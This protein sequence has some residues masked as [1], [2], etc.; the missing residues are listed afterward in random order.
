[1]YSILQAI[2]FEDEAQQDNSIFNVI[3]RKHRKDLTRYFWGDL[4]YRVYS[5]KINNFFCLFIWGEQGTAKSGVGQL[6]AQTIFPKFRQDQVVFSNEE[7][8]QKMKAL[9]V[10][11][12]L[13][14]DEFQKTFGEG[15]YQ[16][17]ATIENY[18]R[19]LRERGNSFI[20]I[21]PDFME[22]KN[23]HYYLR[24]IA[25]DED[26]R[27]AT[28]GLQNPMTNGYM[29]CVN[30][31]LN[32]IWNNEFWK[33]YNKR[34]VS[35]VDDVATNNYEKVDLNEIALEMMEQEEFIKCIFRKKDGD[36]RL[37]MGG[38]KNLVYKYSPNLTT[39]QNN[40]ISQEIKLEF[41]Y[42]KDEFEKAI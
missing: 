10:G 35:F 38:V 36:L 14:R 17:Q 19:Q 25:F 20:Y 21:Q 1:M 7:L 6:I 40:M 27:I 31:N 29:G 41:N 18:T 33:G 24:I 5:K 42:K 26:L 37:D 9:K 32:P 39:G 11:E 16:L 2:K 12:G 30:F 3:S 34:K 13:L 15:T 22:M 23:F 28:A 4:L 8:R